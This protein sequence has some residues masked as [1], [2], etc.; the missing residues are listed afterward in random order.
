MGSSGPR[1]T[2][3]KTESACAEVGEAEIESI[4]DD[5]SV[6]RCRTRAFSLRS[7]AEEKGEEEEEEKVGEELWASGDM[8]CG[9][10]LDGFIRTGGLKYAFWSTLYYWL[11]SHLYKESVERVPFVLTCQ[12]MEVTLKVGWTLSVTATIILFP[13]VILSFCI[14]DFSLF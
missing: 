1:T 2:W 10:M 14:C 9:L 11:L 5:S 13:Q 4:G 8:N 3:A 7:L 6:A 12:V